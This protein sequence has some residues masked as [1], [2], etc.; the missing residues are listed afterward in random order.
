MQLALQMCLQKLLHGHAQNAQQ[1]NPLSFVKMLRLIAHCFAS[2]TGYYK[3][4]LA[5]FH[6][7]HCPRET[8]LLMA[9]ACCTAANLPSC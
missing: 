8:C 2:R 1:A 5:W 7:W 4:K 9:F 6:K 3:R